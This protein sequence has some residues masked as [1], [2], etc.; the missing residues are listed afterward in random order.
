MVNAEVQQVLNVIRDSS[1][2]ILA[3]LNN[4]LELSRC[5]LGSLKLRSQKF[6]LTKEINKLVRRS[7]VLAEK[8]KIELITSID[9]KNRL[10]KGDPIRFCQ[11]MDN[12]I[13]NAMKFTRE[14][15][16]EVKLTEAIDD[17]HKVFF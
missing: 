2:H 15:Y 11:V 16:V 10:R 17:P 1:E 8:K 4:F 6:D 14:G 7:R 5:E 9:L 13:S 12:L 3:L